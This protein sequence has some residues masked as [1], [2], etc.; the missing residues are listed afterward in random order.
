MKRRE[1]YE[2]AFSAKAL[3]ITG[4]L[5]I[6]AFLFNPSTEYRVIQF[7]FFW[8]LVLLCGKKTNP[9]FT[10]L[11]TFFIIAF[12]LIIPY[13]RV[14]FSIGAFKITLG[15]LEAGIHRAVT[16]QALVQL[17]K[18]T[19]R[20]DLKIP[21]SFGKILSESLQMFSVIMSRKYKVT[22][23]NLIADID[24]IM[25]ELSAEQMEIVKEQSMIHTKPAGY[26]LLIF[27]TLVSWLPW[28]FILYKTA[29]L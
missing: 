16:L 4:L 11:I 6:P 14:L 27:T 24:N 18:I 5:I 8:F 19:I 17:S 10:L 9:V 21:G 23:K 15:A 3:F 29:Y 2:N 1:F 22:G 25:L 20:Q 28:V 12:N 13:G 7:L 26:L